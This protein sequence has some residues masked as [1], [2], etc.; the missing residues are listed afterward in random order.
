MIGFT[1]KQFWGDLMNGN[2]QLSWSGDI[3]GSGYIDSDIFKTAISIPSEF[4]GNG[5]GADPKTLLFSSAASCYL[6]TLVGILQVKKID[7][8]K[9]EMVTLVRGDIKSG[10]VV[11]HKPILY[12]SNVV[13]QEK[14]SQIND[15]IIKADESCFVGNVIK[16]SGIIINVEGTIFNN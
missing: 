9:I 4:G 2:I 3:K 8:T 13:Y 10:L 6:M 5:N 16:E 12:V 1:I 15:S 14:V 7:V 11:T